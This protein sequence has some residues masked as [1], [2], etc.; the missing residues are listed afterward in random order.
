MAWKAFP[1]LLKRNRAEE[2][3]AQCAVERQ[4]VA[5]NQGRQLGG[6]AENAC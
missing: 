3:G 1:L 6:E 5:G 2:A 4:C